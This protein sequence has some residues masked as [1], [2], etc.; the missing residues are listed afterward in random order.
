MLRYDPR[1]KPFARILRSNLTDS[2]RLLWSRL[3]GKQILGVQFYRQ[4]SIGEYIV[5]FYAPRV[6]LVVEL[7]GSQHLEP[8][9]VRTDA[10]RS[11]Y[12]EREGLRVLRFNNL[13]ALRQLDAVVEEIARAVET[14][15]N[16]PQ[17]PFSKGGRGSASPF[18]KGRDREEGDDEGRD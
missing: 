16:P 1:M 18:S 4:K 15:L 11:E 9:N 5:D 3:R 2:E 6:R 17:S 12:L 7:D 13:E 8:A 14:E 10:E